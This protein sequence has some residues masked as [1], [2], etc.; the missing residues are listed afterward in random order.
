MQAPFIDVRLLLS[1]LGIR[2]ECEGTDVKVNGV[3]SISAAGASDLAFCH[4]DGEEGFSL[5]SQSNAGI[6]LC[7]SLMQGRAHPKSGRQQFFF[8]VNPRLAFVLITS[9]II[10]KE[11]E[12]MTGIAPY[13]SISNEAKIGSKC[14]I[15]NFTTVGRNCIVGDNTV[16]YEQVSI[17][18]NSTIGDNCIIHPGVTIGA[19]GHAYERLQTGELEGFPHLKGVRIGS[20]VVIGP[21]SNVN[22]G[23]LVDTV[24]CDG[25]KIDALVDIAHN[26][27]IGRNCI[28]TAGSIIGGSTGIGDMSWIGLQST[29]KNNIK[30]GKNVIVGAGAVVLHNVEDGDIVAGVPAKSIKY[31]VHRSKP[32]LYNMAGQK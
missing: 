31:K 27:T 17:V 32:K 6:V 19:D 3:E 4:L 8:M 18:R 13:A 28:I 7:S 26:V 10:K 1:D 2:H 24:I 15:G 9:Q 29:I 22:R 12:M 5:I 23:S 25:T 21:N 30:I 11:E 16:I 20:N 14:Y